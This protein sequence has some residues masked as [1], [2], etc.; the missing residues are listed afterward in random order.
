[1]NGSQGIP[2]DE[3]D[4]LKADNYQLNLELRAR[5]IESAQAQMQLLK[6]MLNEHVAGMIL[7]YVGADANLNAWHYHPGAKELRPLSR[8]S[9]ASESTNGTSDDPGVALR[10]CDSK[11][12]LSDG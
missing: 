2:V 8:P 6:G 1:M 4:S 9:G 11:T 12:E 5:M 7:K 3:L 10:G